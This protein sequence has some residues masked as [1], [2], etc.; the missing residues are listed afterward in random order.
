MRMATS[1]ST[2][3]PCWGFDYAPFTQAGGLGKARQLFPELPALLNELN[4]VLAA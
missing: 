2:P 4:T 1:C 3:T